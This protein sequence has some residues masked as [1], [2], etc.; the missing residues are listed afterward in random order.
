MATARTSRSTPG[1]C[2][3]SCR[4][5]WTRRA[6]TSTWSAARPSPARATSSRCRAPW[7][8][9]G[10]DRSRARPPA[11]RAR[12]GHAGDPRR[13]EHVMG[14]PVSLAMRGRHAADAAGSTA[15]DDAV[16]VLRDADR[17]FSTYRPD[18]VVSRLGRGELDPADRPAEVA[19]VLGI[20]ALA[21][22]ESGGAFAVRRPGADG[23]VMLDPSGVVKGW[24]VER[25]AAP[26]SAL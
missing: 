24:A 6:P 2:R 18:S 10:C 3:C 16:A 14:V 1:P 9:P 17:V 7:T 20:G 5:R 22:Q 25:A 21:E 4:R 11:G 15:W 23:A 26:L 8:R 19:E 13:V 12:P